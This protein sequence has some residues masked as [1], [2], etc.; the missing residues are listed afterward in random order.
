MAKTSK[1]TVRRRRPRGVSLKTAQRRIELLSTRSVAAATAPE[2]LD[3]RLDPDLRTE[4]VP[5]RH[6]VALSVGGQTVSQL[7]VVDLQQQIGSQIVRMGGIAD[8]GTHDQ[9]RFK[10]YMRRVLAGALCWMRRE[11]FDTSMLYGITSFYPKFGYAPAFPD[12]EF[13][14]NVRDAEALAPAG[15]RF[16]AFKS[17][18]LRAIIDLYHGAIAGRTGPTRRDAASWK[19]FRMGATWRSE[20][21]C[22]VALDRRRRPVG[23]FVYD[24]RYLEAR[25]IEVGAVRPGVFADVLRAAA[26]HALRQRLEQ[27]HF[28]LAE[29]DPFVEFCKPLGLRKE[30][31]YTRDGHA[32][33]RMINVPSALSNVAVELGSRMRGSGRLNLRTNL[34]GVGL[35]WG[36]GRLRVTAPRP[37]APSARMPQW[38]LAQLLYGYRS[39]TGLADGGILRGGPAAIDAL[40]RMFP[41]TQ[42]YQYISDRF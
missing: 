28:H 42:H 1:K 2:R 19:P 40:E 25:V 12:V 41:V 14:M 11:G 32:M 7:W 36:G 37:G 30:V 13:T 35:A 22:K 31:R 5:P 39:A 23:Y 4:S 6:H 18:H 34:D 3:G 24:A 9:H 10:G 29:D 38:A 21:V 8:V 26:R 20:A 33:V 17:A 15:H 16:V 27:I